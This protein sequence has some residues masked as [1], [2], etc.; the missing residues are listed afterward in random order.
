M[1]GGG[2]RLKI[3][4]GIQGVA[5][6]TKV[7]VTGFELNFSNNLR[8]PEIYQIFES[9]EGKDISL[10]GGRSGLYLTDVI[11]NYICGILI[12]FRDDKKSVVTKKNEDG[13]LSVIKSELR[14]DEHAT[15]ASVFCINPATKSGLLYTYFGGSNAA[16]L[17]KIFA[18]AHTKARRYAIK[19]YIDEKVEQSQNK[20]RRKFREKAEEHFKGNFKLKVKVT[21]K[22][23][24]DLLSEFKEVNSVEIGATGLIESIPVLTPII[25]VYKKSRIAIT[26]SNAF[27]SIA[28]H[29][30]IRDLANNVGGFGNDEVFKVIGKSHSGEELARKVGDNTSEF[31]MLSYDDYIDKLPS[32]TWDDYRSCA[33]CIALISKIK[34]FCAVFGHP[35]NLTTWKIPSAKDGGS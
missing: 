1:C 24:E 30:N 20:K 27:R 18:I 16:A 22:D 3:D 10:S 23:I 15:E 28:H 8:M 6:S 34:H 7:K 19:D 21:T 12:T 35:N 13:K 5:V 2:F 26:I 9:M 4:K 17:S 33:A 32:T 14:K 11:D 29:T 31:G 25:S